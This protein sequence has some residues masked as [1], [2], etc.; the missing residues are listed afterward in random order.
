MTY[1]IA[2]LTAAAV[3]SGLTFAQAQ[4]VEIRPGGVAVDQHR[5]SGDHGQAHGGGDRH[6][7]VI[8]NDH[9]DNGHGT[10]GSHNS[11]AVQVNPGHSSGTGIVV[12]PDTN[13]R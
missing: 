5:D 1:K 13:R 8:Q 12:D 11:P 10:V 7:V 9:R 3:V 4:T 2:I 6:G